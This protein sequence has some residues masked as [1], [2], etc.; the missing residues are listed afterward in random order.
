[1]MREKWRRL[2]WYGK[3]ALHFGKLFAFQLVWG[4]VVPAAAFFLS[5][6]MFRAGVRRYTSANG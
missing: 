2:R 6:R 4:C 3:V 5:R 1:M